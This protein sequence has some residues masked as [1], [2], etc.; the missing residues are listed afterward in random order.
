MRAPPASNRPMIGAPDLHRLAL[1]LE[2]LLGMGARKRSPEDREILGEDEHHPAVDPAPAGDHAV[3]GDALLRHAELGDRV[4]D[5][6]VELLERALVEQQVDALAG[7]Q[8]AL[9]V[10]AGDPLGAAAL[11]RPSRRFSSS[12]RMCFTV[13]AFAV[14]GAGVVAR[15][16][17][18]KLTPGQP[19]ARQMLLTPM[20]F[21]LCP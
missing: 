13:R 21:Q 2:D 19:R 17:R 1:H 9:G 14:R 20:G 6:H 10:L 18:G 15:S 16:H 12:S 8:L 11:R 7:G 4:L 5:E 3:A